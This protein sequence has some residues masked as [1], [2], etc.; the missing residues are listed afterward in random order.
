MQDVTA[1][2]ALLESQNRVLSMALIHQKL[3]QD[4]QI[5]KVEFA[6]FADELFGQ[7]KG[8]FGQNANVLFN[9]EMNET[10]LGINTAIPL[11]LILNELITNSLKYAFDQVA[12]P[13]I[14]IT[15]EESGE[16]SILTYTDNGPGLPADVDLN[17][18]TTMG[19]RLVSRLSKQLKGSADYRTDELSSF[20]IKFAH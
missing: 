19:L 20:I 15:F 18:V 7:L 1:R 13:F 5:D 10:F 3:Y 16:W 11:G 17:Q 6:T 14:K 2:N 8:V 4:E 12:T 9:N